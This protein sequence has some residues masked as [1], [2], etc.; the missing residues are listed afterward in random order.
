MVR[1]ARDLNRPVIV[2]RA[3]ISQKSF[4]DGVTGP[5][6]PSCGAG[7]AA[8]ALTGLLSDEDCLRTMC[9]AIIEMVTDEVP[10]AGVARRCTQVNRRFIGSGPQ[11][12][13][14]AAGREE[15]L[16]GGL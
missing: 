10:W 3:R 6:V 16:V 5:V 11:R 14:G 13:V 8:A 1:L 15:G 9:Q 7:D 4:H 12:K 2:T